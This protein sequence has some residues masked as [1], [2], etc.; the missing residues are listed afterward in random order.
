[1]FA[2]PLDLRSNRSILPRFHRL[3]PGLLRPPGL[4]PSRTFSLASRSTSTMS[5]LPS[6][7]PQPP[8]SGNKFSVSVLSTYSSDSTPSLLVTFPDQRY[9][10]NTPEAISRVAV[11]SKVGLRKVGN[12]FLGSIEE[13]AGLPGFILSSV[14]AGNNKIEIV[15]P[16]GADHYLASCRFFTRRSVLFR[17]RVIIVH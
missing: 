8:Q 6:A 16:A 10:F 2:R 4:I 14:E 12:V 17:N 9:L 1:M 5:A 3:L 13:S 11:Q 15:G 7:I